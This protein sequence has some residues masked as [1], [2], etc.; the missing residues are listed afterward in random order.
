MLRGERFPLVSSGF[1]VVI[2]EVMLSKESSQSKPG[3]LKVKYYHSQ[4]RILL[5]ESHNIASKKI[6]CVTSFRNPLHVCVESS[7][8]STTCTL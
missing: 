2:F 5:A 1:S 3:H 6:I 8:V 7:T 4:G